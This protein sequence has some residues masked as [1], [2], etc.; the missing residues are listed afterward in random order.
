MICEQANDNDE[1]YARLEE[2]GVKVQSLKAAELS[3]EQLSELHGYFLRLIKEYQGRH[4]EG[5]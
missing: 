2:L 4:A 3:T 1:I 5:N